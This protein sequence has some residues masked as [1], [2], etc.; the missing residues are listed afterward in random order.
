[1]DI[2]IADLEV[3]LTHTIKNIRSLGHDLEQPGGGA[4]G[5]I[6][7]SEEEGEDGLGDLIIT[8]F[9]EQRGW[10]LDVLSWQAL[11]VS[12][13]PL[14]GQQHVLDPGIHD[15][16]GLAASGKTGLALGGCLGE[17]G[18]DHVTGFLAIP[19][20]GEGEDDREVDKLEGLGDQVVVVGDLLD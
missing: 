6:L 3:L 14:L 11:G 15:T 8:E 16:V 1:M 5:G 13:G 18:K 2:T 10:L 12:L 20:L 17:L 19:R 7:G 9:T 4:A